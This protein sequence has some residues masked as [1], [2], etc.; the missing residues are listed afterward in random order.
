MKLY[1]K[2][3]EK[4]AKQMFFYHMRTANGQRQLEKM[5]EFPLSNMKQAFGSV[6]FSLAKWA[7]RHIKA[8]QLQREGT[9]SN[10]IASIMNL[11]TVP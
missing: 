8:G 6:R 3:T 10:K 11:K 5:F 7:D 2:I 4:E 9:L 1:G